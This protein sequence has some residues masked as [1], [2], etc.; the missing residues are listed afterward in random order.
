MA[1]RRGRGRKTNRFHDDPIINRYII[2]LQKYK[3]Y[4]YVR[5]FEKSLYR[6]DNLPKSGPLH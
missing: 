2:V 6:V 3:T 4:V 5:S 1:L